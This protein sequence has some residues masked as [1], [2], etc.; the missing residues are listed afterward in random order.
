MRPVDLAEEKSAGIVVDE[1]A[2]LR[3]MR[4]NGTSLLFESILINEDPESTAN[5]LNLH[6][7]R[8]RMAPDDILEQ[9][10]L[11]DPTLNLPGDPIGR[12][13]V[14]VRIVPPADKNGSR[15]KLPHAIDDRGD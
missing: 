6:R 15:V 8:K 1:I 11:A 9:L 10:P 13:M 4:G 12:L 3:S 5:R 2:C 14:A 7:R